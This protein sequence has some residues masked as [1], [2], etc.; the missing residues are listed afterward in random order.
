MFFVSFTVGKLCA[1]KVLKTLTVKF[2]NLPI[3][4]QMLIYLIYK[5]TICKDPLANF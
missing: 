4:V 1:C 5:V 3:T 2:V